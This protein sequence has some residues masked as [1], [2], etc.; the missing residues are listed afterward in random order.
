MI[1]AETETVIAWFYGWLDRHQARNHHNGWRA[2]EEPGRTLVYF[3]WLRAF[4]ARGVTKADAESASI[5]MQTC[6]SLYPEHHLARLLAI[7]APIIAS[8]RADESIRR[9]RRESEEWA[10]DQDSYLRDRDC[11]RLLAEP[12]RHGM[13]ASIR[14]RYPQ[15]A[16]VAGFVERFAVE[17]W[18][19]WDLP[20]PEELRSRTVT[21]TEQRASAETSE[22]PLTEGQVAFL[23]ALAP[24]HSAFLERCS[25]GKRRLLLLPHAERFDPTAMVAVAAELRPSGTATLAVA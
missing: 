8:R 1:V 10:R 19:G 3:G 5:K 20:D 14:R 4:E 7:T 24:E 9:Q 13:L 11:W 2:F 25:P 18:L 22:P 15:I 6:E 16:E 21:A 23:G 17:E 12:E